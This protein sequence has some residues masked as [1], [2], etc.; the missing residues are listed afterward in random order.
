MSKSLTG[1]HANGKLYVDK[2]LE[3]GAAA[4][5][6]AATYGKDNVVNGSMG[7]MRDE[8]GALICLPTV[9]ALFKSIEMQN[10]ISYSPIAGPQD[11]QDAAI[12][13]TFGDYQPEGYIKAIAT[14]GGAGAVSATIWNYSDYGDTVLTHDWFWSPYKWM[15]D[16][17]GRKLDTFSLYTE[18]KI[19]NIA[20]FES[21]VNEILKKQDRIVIILNTP[22]NNPTGFTLTDAEWDA[23]LWV[24][25][26]NAKKDK[27]ITLLIDIAYIDFTHDPVKVR[28][29]M[30]KFGDLPANILVTLAF[31]MSKSFTAYG[32]RTGA[33]IGLSSSKEVIEEFTHVTQVTGRTR[34]S[35]G[36]TGCMNIMAKIYSDPLLV[37]ALE[38][39]RAD[40]MAI[41]AKRADIFVKEASELELD[42][43][44]YCGGF[45]ITLPTD[46]PGLACEY[47]QKRNIFLVPLSKGIRIAVCSIPAAQV[48]GL[49]EQVVESLATTTRK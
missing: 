48:T 40:S 38:K 8:E 7:V 18:D 6:A 33:V 37:K 31:S 42:V 19:F 46:N 34:W 43:L 45:F 20:S 12:R 10:L 39:E 5:R 44:P 36:N 2:L 27:S 26:E 25:K 41:I 13:H 22:G 17:I 21:K 1:L 47:L 15:C 24:V 29:F 30:K 23:V 9:E 35:N 14:P 3:T 4:Q 49:A 16:E 11:Y 28:A 32:Q